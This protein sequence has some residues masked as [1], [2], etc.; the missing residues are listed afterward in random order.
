MNRR[1]V[2]LLYLT[3]LPLWRLLVGV[4]GLAGVGVGAFIAWR[5]DA[6]TPLL[7]VSTVLVGLALFDWTELT[8]RHGESSATLKRTKKQIQDVASRE[9]VPEQ[10]RE[11]LQDAALA[12]DTLSSSWWRDLR[13]SSAWTTS[14][15]LL[16]TYYTVSADAT[17]ERA[18]DKLLVKFVPHTFYTWPNPTVVCTI[19]DPANRKA[20]SEQKPWASI[21]FTYPDDFEGADGLI[22]GEYV[23]E[24]YQPQWG[25]KVVEAR[26]VVPS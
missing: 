18:D 24:W 19:T 1:Q 17:I 12:I 26:I 7:I 10:A 3:A 4:A 13:S 5:A 22:P 2:L 14:S 9:D 25:T 20:S 6:A 11:Q 16:Q 8:L 15:P 21:T 23:A